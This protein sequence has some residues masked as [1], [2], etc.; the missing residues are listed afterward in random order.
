[1]KVT[2]VHRR[3]KA[4]GTAPS[5][6]LDDEFNQTQT[7][8]KGDWFYYYVYMQSFLKGQVGQLTG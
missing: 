3:V 7:G 5:S 1:M 2:G 8:E 6:P 4:S